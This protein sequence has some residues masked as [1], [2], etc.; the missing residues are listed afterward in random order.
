[1]EV[2]I[3]VYAGCQTEGFADLIPLVSVE[4]ERWYIAPGV[5]RI[6]VT[7]HGLTGTLFLP[8]GGLTGSFSVG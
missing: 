2:T 4:V 8:S 5:R 3:S 6:P 1:M 7:E